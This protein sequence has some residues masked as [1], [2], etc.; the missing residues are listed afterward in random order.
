MNDGHYTNLRNYLEEIA[1]QNKQIIE[2]LQDIRLSNNRIDDRLK[3]SSKEQERVNWNSRTQEESETVPDDAVGP[4][5]IGTVKEEPLKTT[6]TVKVV[7]KRGTVATIED[8]PFVPRRQDAPVEG[9]AAMGT[10]TEP[11]PAD[12]KK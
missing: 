9:L 10:M 7:D 2:L 3:V 6:E 8:A 4:L 12:K 5:T 1:S 11:K